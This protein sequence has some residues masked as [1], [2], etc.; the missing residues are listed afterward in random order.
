MKSYKKNFYK[1]L[2]EL[3]HRSL[4]YYKDRLVSF[5]VFGS[6]AKDSFTPESDIDLI[7]ILE[8]TKGRYEDYIEYSENIEDKLKTLKELKKNHIY[9]RINPIFKNKNS[10]NFHLSYLWDNSFLI[11]YD[12]DNFFLNFAEELKN[13]ERDNLKF[14][15]EKLP[16]IEVK[17]G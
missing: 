6:V 3:S 16:Y 1:I 5:V 10:L 14:H 12:K 17:S 13:H 8:K 11:L 4:K 2:K 9:I 7:I 15:T